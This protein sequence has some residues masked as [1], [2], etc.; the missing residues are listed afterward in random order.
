M[1]DENEPNNDKHE[2]SSRIDHTDL[3][4]FAGVAQ[5]YFTSQGESQRLQ[6]QQDKDVLAFQKSTFKHRFWFY[7]WM[8][9]A[10]FAMAAGII[11]MLG[12]IDKGL[13]VLSHVGAVIAGLLAGAGLERV[14]LST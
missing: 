6:A 14:R 8:S 4:T 9:I 2:R 11:F 5:E 7:L 13:S 10:I 12:E 1:H 3:M